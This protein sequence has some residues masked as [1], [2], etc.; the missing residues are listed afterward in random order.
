MTRSGVRDQPDQYDETPSLLKIQKLARRGGMHLLHKRPKK[1]GYGKLP[2]KQIS[3]GLQEGEQELMHKLRG[4]CTP[5]PQEQELL[6]S[7]SFQTPPCTASQGW[8]QWLTPVIPALWE[9]K[10]GGSRGQEIETI[11][12]NT[13]GVQW[14]DLSS[15][16]PPPPGFKRFSCLSLLSSW[17]YRGV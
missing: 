2:E 16:H 17:D 5:A 13:A 12:A 4:G 3:R 15:L 8:A 6:H 1:T 10:A 14:H 11:L 7:G 9:A